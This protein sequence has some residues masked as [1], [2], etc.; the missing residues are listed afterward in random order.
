MAHNPWMYFE[1]CAKDRASSRDTAEP[2]DVRLAAQRCTRR[3]AIMTDT[4]ALRG[5][6]GKQV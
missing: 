2:D 4:D 6:P 1:D 5:A 3:H